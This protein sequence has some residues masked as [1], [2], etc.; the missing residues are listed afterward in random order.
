MPG[1]KIQ[2]QR[3]AD[4]CVYCWDEGNEKWV[5]VSPVDTLP[6]DIKQRVQKDKED[7]EALM[8]VGIY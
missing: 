8:S 7:A 2:Y 3:E 6:D 4:G 1:Y 5:K